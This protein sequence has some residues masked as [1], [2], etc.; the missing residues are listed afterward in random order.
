LW[1][2]LKVTEN[3][4]HLIELNHYSR[5]IALDFAISLYND[6]FLPHPVAF[7]EFKKKQGARLLIYLLRGDYF[8]SISKASGEGSFGISVRNLA[9]EG[10]VTLSRRFD[11]L[12]YTPETPITV[13]LLAH[14]INN[15]NVQSISVKE[16]IPEGWSF[17]DPVQNQSYNEN[18]YI[19]LTLPPSGSASYT[20]IPPV[21]AT[22]C[23]LFRAEG[24]VTLTGFNATNRLN[25]IQ[26]LLCPSPQDG[27]DTDPQAFVTETVNLEMNENTEVKKWDIFDSTNSN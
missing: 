4:Y 20:V 7:Q 16:H 15:T 3:S 27:N 6:K 25:S 21:D 12:G 18:G 1:Y 10:P 26:T 2:S 11:S 23:Q 13:T 5:D 22:G 14:G 8:L 17:E 24:L 19:S 9:K